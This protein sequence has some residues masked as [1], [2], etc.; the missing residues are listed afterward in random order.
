MKTFLLLILSLMAVCVA[1]LTVTV[2]QEGWVEFTCNYKKPEEEYHSIVVKGPNTG[3]IPST[4]QDQRENGGRFSMCHNTDTKTLKVAIKNLKP[5]DY[6]EYEC[7]LTSSDEEEVEVVVNVVPPA[8]STPPVF[9]TAISPSAQNKAARSPLTV[10]IAVVV[11][12]VLLVLVLILVFIY[13]RY[14]RS[15]NTANKNAQNEKEDPAYEE[16]Q[17]RPREPDSGTAIKTIYT[18]AIFDTNTSPGIHHYSN[19]CVKNSSVEFNDGDPYSTVNN[20]D[21]H[22]VYST[23]NHPSG[24]SED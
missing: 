3:P 10:I 14:Q 22:P 4:L 21:Q 2:C 5:K 9:S 7:E 8:T 1:S 16:I 19:S 18:T 13:K 23:L 15:K 12:A 17:E 6:G 11:C 24:L 20:N